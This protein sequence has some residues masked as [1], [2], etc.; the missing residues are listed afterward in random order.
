[1]KET[2]LALA[3]VGAP[4]VSLEFGVRVLPSGNI[5]NI[6]LGIMHPQ[7][8][9]FSYSICSHVFLTRTG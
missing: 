4:H 1:M 6:G 5:E 2:A 9:R 3:V 8:K 7:A